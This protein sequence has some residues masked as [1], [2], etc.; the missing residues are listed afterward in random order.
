MSIAGIANS[1]F[2]AP[3]SRF[4][5]VGLMGLSVIEEVRKRYNLLYPKL[6]L[7]FWERPSCF[8]SFGSADDRSIYKH[9]SKALF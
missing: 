4:P 2:G 1:A 8:G 5:N 3:S 6:E 9:I 7:S